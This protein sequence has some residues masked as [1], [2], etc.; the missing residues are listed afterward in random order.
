MHEILSKS[1][2]HGIIPTLDT[3]IGLMRILCRLFF[4]LASFLASSL[5]L[6]ACSAPVRPVITLHQLDNKLVEKNQPIHYASVSVQVTDNRDHNDA[7]AVINPQQSVTGFFQLAIQNGLKK[8]GFI[9]LSNTT[10]PEKTDNQIDLAILKINYQALSGYVSSN[11]VTF[12][13]VKLTAKNHS[14]VY[15]NVYNASSYGDYYLTS[16][17]QTPSEQTSQAVNKLLNN[18]INDAKL[19]DFLNA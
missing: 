6:F 17:Q 16:I 2:N 19:I 5:G 7:E 18:I 11:M 15:T 12:V 3:W 1:I 9:V 14:G 4:F 10:V 8:R 13:T